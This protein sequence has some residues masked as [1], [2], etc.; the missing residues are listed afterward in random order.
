MKNLKQIIDKIELNQKSIQAYGKFTDEVLKK[1]N[2][3]LRLDWNYYSNRM[4]GGTL[5]RSETRSVMVGNIEV[6]NKPIKDVMEMHGHDKAVLDVLK[7]GKGEQRISEKRI[8]EFHKAIMH[9]DTPNLKSCIGKW[10]TE[11]NEII[12]YKDEKIPFAAP[13]DVPDAIHKLLDKTNAQ[14]DRLYS[15]NTE[16]HPLEIAAQF[17]IDFVTIHPFYD[18]NGRMA[19]ILTNIILVACGYA[20]IIIKDN[21]KKS[22]YQLLADVQAYGG[23]PNLFYEFIGERLLNTQQLILDALEGKEIDEPDDLDK[24]LAFL[25][26]EM[27]AEDESNEVKKSLD[28]QFFANTFNNWVLPLLDE[29][30]NVT[31]KF[32]RFYD[33]N[34]H[35]Y[36]VFAGGKSFNSTYKM[37]RDDFLLALQNEDSRNFIQNKVEVRFTAVFDAYK[38]GGVNPFDCSYHLIIEFERYTYSIQGNSFKNG[39]AEVI[40]Y[41]KKLLHHNLTPTEQKQI[42]KDWGDNLLAHLEYHRKNVKK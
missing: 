2:Y 18:G 41:G 14:I 42:I 11:A 4:E 16:I 20:P 5:T 27:L 1:I 13:A 28:P 19:R 22:Y 38:K 32:N 24:K 29:L 33:K 31:N 40:N 30:T 39:K 35:N 37:D 25:E 17:H 15:G 12:N 6:H 34:N 8:K 7:M 3:K 36:N 26:K 10:K 23:K 21:Q 9:E